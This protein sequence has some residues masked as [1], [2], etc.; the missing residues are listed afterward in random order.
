MHSSAEKNE[1]LQRLDNA[2]EGLI[3]AVSGL[4]E[5]QA[6]FK[7]EPDAWSV[8][9]IV[10]HLAT[11]EDFVVMRLEKIASEPDDGHFKDSDVVLFDRVA[12]RSVK[13]QAPERVQPA[14]KPLG[15][16]LERLVATRARI[17]ELIRSAPDGH[18]REHSMSHPVFGPL[19]GH[20]WIVAV[21]G[22]C[23]RHTQQILATKAAPNFPGA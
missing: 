16:S 1:L 3:T 17:V 18:F 22:H 5:S 12:D 19:D 9:G 8:A 14:G 21:A 6:N 11:V 7:P 10:E 15:S 4:S 20:Q 13:I 2:R 23:N